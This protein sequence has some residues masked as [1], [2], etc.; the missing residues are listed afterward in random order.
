MFTL[1]EIPVS[2][3][4]TM[5]KHFEELLFYAPGFWLSKDKNLTYTYGNQN[6]LSLL[7]FTTLEELIG[8]TDYELPWRN[9]YAGLYQA[10]DKKVLKGS[11]MINYI[12]KQTIDQKTIYQVRVSKIPWRGN[13][14]SECSILC[15][16]Q[17]LNSLKPYSF[18][19]LSKQQRNCLNLIIKGFTA[20]EIAKQ[21]NLSTRTVEGYTEIIKEKLN[22]K[23]KAEIIIK[24]LK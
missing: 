6:F 13:N 22:C 4:M 24:L 12:E 19:K 3:E 5:F 20:K 14:N 17:M 7:G 8:K 16:Y 18:C 15:Y 11:V 9:R 10:D 1:F 2:P 23:S 21:L